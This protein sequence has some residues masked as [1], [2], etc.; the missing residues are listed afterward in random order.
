[1]NVDSAQLTQINFI[2]SISLES[3]N[4]WLCQ[5]SDESINEFAQS[6]L[7]V[8]SLSKFFQLPQI[9]NPLGTGSIWQ[10]TATAY[11]S[12][13]VDTQD[14]IENMGKCIV[15]HLLQAAIFLDKGSE[16]I[17]SDEQEGQ[18]IQILNQLS[19]FDTKYRQL[20]DIALVF[21][22]KIRNNTELLQMNRQQIFAL[23]VLFKHACN[24]VDSFV[25][26]ETCMPQW[27]RINKL[28]ISSKGFLSSLF[29]STAQCISSDLHHMED[30][31]EI[32]PELPDGSVESHAKASADIVN[33]LANYLAFNK[34][35]KALT[36]IKVCPDVLKLFNNL[37]FFLKAKPK[38]ANKKANHKLVD[39][40][41]SQNL[42][43][44]EVLNHQKLI[45]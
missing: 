37:S 4:E 2:K 23:D 29:E 12:P 38:N 27:W 5:L 10:H 17:A 21:S 13:L 3:T 30:M 40:L 15:A 28:V 6:E 33:D 43:S 19:L 24:F 26:F 22:K 25:L 35:F 41:R 7:D 32:Y 34:T 36:A 44:F 45:K 16:V 14:A 1:M 31:L 39:A 20:N 42:V 11:N 18:F 9:E 8:D